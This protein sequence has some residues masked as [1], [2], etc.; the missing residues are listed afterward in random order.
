MD[1]KIVLKEMTD[2]FY[3]VHDMEAAKKL[4][5]FL[6]GKIFD[7][8]M[9][10]SDRPFYTKDILNLSDYY[11]D[12]APRMGNREI[13]CN[14]IATPYTELR[15]KNER[16][17]LT[18]FLVNELNMYP[19]N[20]GE[21]HVRPDDTEEDIEAQIIQHPGIRGLK[22]YHL[23]ADRTDTFNAGIEEYLPEAAWEVA[24]KHA[25]AITLHMVRPKAL[26]DDDNR[27]YIKEMSKRYPNATLILAH[28]ARSFA[29]WTAIEYV[30]ELTGCENVWFDFSGICESTGMVAIL[31]K[32]GVSRCM[33]GSDWNVSMSAGKAISIGGTFYWITAN[34][35]KNFNSKTDF[36]TYLVGTENLMATR[37]ACILT[38]QN[39]DAVEDLFYNNAARLFKR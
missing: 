33:W 14:G 36:H 17:K 16:Q 26:A 25:L 11:N 28:A 21:I 7:A 5:A 2:N 3:S 32:V 8:H 27:S 39:E 35:I 37:E 20:V 19:Q 6:P 31:N 18:D 1:K 23:L 29:A 22:C 9:H 15:D 13:V 10:I 12:S 4:D 24:N 30:G 38:N 34:D